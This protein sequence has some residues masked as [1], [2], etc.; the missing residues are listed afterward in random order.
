MRILCHLWM[1]FKRKKARV[2]D[3][4]VQRWVE[5]EE[6]EQ[7][8]TASMMILE[9]E[10]SKSS[11][12]I[13]YP[14]HGSI[15]QVRPDG[16]FQGMSVQLNSM[17]YDVQ[18]VGIGEVGVNWT[19]AVRKRLLLLLPDITVEARTMTAHNTNKNIA[20]H[21]QGGIATMAFGELLNY[22]KKGSKDFCHLGRWRS[23]I[24][25]SI[26]G[27]RMRIVQD[28]GVR[29]SHSMILG[30]VDQQHHHYIQLNGLVNITPRQLF[31]S[32]LIWQ[33]QM[34]RSM[35]DRIILL[36]DINCHVLTGQL[37]CALT[38]EGVKLREITKDH[39]DFLCPNTHA[40]G[41]KQIDGVWATPD[42]TIT[43]VKWLPY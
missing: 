42:I 21:Q 16:I 15:L 30:L 23:F 13:D 28:Y 3:E 40:S 17:K 10:L 41:S 4:D 22:Y 33:L 2:T 35:E 1:S 5:L 9:Q 27:H 7:H 32:D 12:P 11:P 26:R 8:N 36:M 20:I 31:E 24:L 43:S 14:A 39:L 6:N 18:F 37:S 34:W 19:K 38:G 25:Q 29:S